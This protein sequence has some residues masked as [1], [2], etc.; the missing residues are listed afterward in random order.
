[1]FPAGDMRGETGKQLVNKYH[2]LYMEK[3]QELFNTSKDKFASNR[4][5]D[6]RFVE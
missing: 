6:L 3:L 5:S 4:V 1:M 2:Q